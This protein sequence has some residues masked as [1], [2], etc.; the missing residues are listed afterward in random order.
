VTKPRGVGRAARGDTENGAGKPRETPPELRPTPGLSPTDEAIV[1]LLQGDGRTPISEIA[2]N[3]GLATK[4]ASRRVDHLIEAGVIDITAV[5]TPDVLGYQAGALLGLRVL[6]NVQV[7]QIVE[8]LWRDQRIDYM[9]VVGGPYRLIVEIFGRDAAEL[10]AAIERDVSQIAG[11]SD[12]ELFPYLSL[13]YQRF[14][15][16]PHASD[17]SAVSASFGDNRSRELDFMDKKI[18]AELNLDGRRK[19]QSLGDELGVSESQVRRRVKRMVDSGSLR[20]MAMAN[21]SSLGYGSLAWLA[22]NVAGGESVRAV[23]ERLSQ[24]AGV[25]YI[26]ITSG[27][28]DLFVDV[29]ARDHDDLLRLLDEEVRTV[30]GVQAVQT[31][32]HLDLHWRPLRP[33]LPIR[34]EGGSQ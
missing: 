13:Y 11:I 34:P 15:F 8:E 10:R 22:V 33:V 24:V 31:W 17:D 9:S 29:V 32:L 1:Q 6:P 4:A 3:V 23:A 28:Y 20:I 7:T 14:R 25:I 21:P 30:P 2:Q 16:D 12:V 5:T 19:F 18:V 27:R 26:I